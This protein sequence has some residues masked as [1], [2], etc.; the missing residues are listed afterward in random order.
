[1][2]ANTP[3][4]GVIC[5]KVLKQVGRRKANDDEAGGSCEAGYE[6]W[7]QLLVR[8]FSLSCLHGQQFTMNVYKFAY[9]FFVLTMRCEKL[10]YNLGLVGWFGFA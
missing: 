2:G 1:M 7:S 8:D 6:F 4:T 3:H 9:C 5:P 10:F